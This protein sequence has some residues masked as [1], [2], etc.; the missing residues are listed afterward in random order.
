A[1]ELTRLCEALVERDDEQEREQE[2][3]A[4]HRDP[5]LAQ[6]LGELA[7][8]AIRLGLLLLGNALHSLRRCPRAPGRY[9][10]KGWGSR[11]RAAPREA[12]RHRGGGVALPRESGWGGRGRGAGGCGGRA[13]ARGGGG[14]RRGWGGG[15]WG[16]RG[17]RED[18]M[19]VLVAD[20]AHE[21]GE[22]PG[23]GLR[24]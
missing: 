4:R 1:L 14:P 24:L 19:H 7:L 6:Q 12:G 16:G 5:Q 3:H 23:R 20:R 9:R 2:L 11:I 10:L 8:A 17:P 22:L 21:L 18:R 15:V 13:G